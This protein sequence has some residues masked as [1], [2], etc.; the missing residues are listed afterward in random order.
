MLQDT[1]QNNE[2]NRSYIGLS[3]FVCQITAV[4]RR[5]QALVASPQNLE[6]YKLP[7]EC[8]NSLCN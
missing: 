6:I 2:A 7:K 5:I 1:A 8:S 3:E 4:F